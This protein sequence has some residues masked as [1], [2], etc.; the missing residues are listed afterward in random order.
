MALMRFLGRSLFASAFIVDGAKML[1]SDKAE[2]AADPVVSAVL[3]AAKGILPNEIAGVLPE[4]PKSWAKIQGGAEILGGTLYATGWLRRIGA[5]ILL[6]TA[7]PKVISAIVDDRNHDLIGAMALT[8][9]ALVAVGDTHGNP[10]LGWRAQHGVRVA[11]NNIEN[12]VDDVSR[13]AKKA[14]KKAERQ[15]KKTAKQAERQAKKAFN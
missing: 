1:T 5:L 4:D 15:A 10:S 8:G 13:K 12:T 11:K 6:G 2:S 9:G 14:A 3:P 7:V